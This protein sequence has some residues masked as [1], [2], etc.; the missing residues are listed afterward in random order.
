MDK[1]F[2]Q[3]EE[4]L[5]KGTSKNMRV[6]S[7]PRDAFAKIPENDRTLFISEIRQMQ[8]SIGVTFK[9]LHRKEVVG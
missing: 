5:P 4:V 7:L 2:D 3:I 1:F 9:V 8:A 6:R